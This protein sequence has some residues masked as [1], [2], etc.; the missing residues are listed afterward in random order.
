MDARDNFE[1]EEMEG[2]GKIDEQLAQQAQRMQMEGEENRIVQGS[3]KEATP[4]SEMILAIA[5]LH[6]QASFG[7][8]SSDEFSARN[9]KRVQEQTGGVKPGR[10]KQALLE[11]QQ[12]MADD[13][14]AQMDSRKLTRALKRS[15]RVDGEQEV[16]NLEATSQGAAGKLTGSA[17]GSRQEQ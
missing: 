11:Y 10:V 13:T 8:V 6:Q 12:A 2:D 17:L 5:N 7:E 16:D 14:T 15:R 3:A 1:A 4:N 9:R